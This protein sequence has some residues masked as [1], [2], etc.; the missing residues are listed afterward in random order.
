[1]ISWDWQ[2]ARMVLIFTPRQIRWLRH[3]L[4]QYRHM[5]DQAPADH[6]SSISSIVN[7][8]PNQGGVVIVDDSRRL[9]WAWV[10]Q[11]LLQL[12]LSRLKTS[13]G[14]SDRGV[15]AADGLRSWLG[16]VIARLT[17]DIAVDDRFEEHLSELVRDQERRKN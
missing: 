11:D 8:L 10:L 17:A 3:H 12:T 16:D 9:S 7:A 1:M 2:G 5:N 6:R 13:H 14:D 15:R 4:T